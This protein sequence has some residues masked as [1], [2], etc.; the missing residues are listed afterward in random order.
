[1]TKNTSNKLAATLL[2]IL[3]LMGCGAF[4]KSTNETHAQPGYQAVFLDSGAVFFGQLQGLG[5]EYPILSHAF[6]VAS[7]TNPETKQ[8][9]NILIK[10]GKEWHGPD[11]VTLNA[12]HILFAEPVTAGSQV[13]TLIEKAAQEVVK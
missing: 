5:T 12:H 11:H 13:A 10:R 3:A 6:Y 2:P 8:P 9:S 1:M 4:A 7:V